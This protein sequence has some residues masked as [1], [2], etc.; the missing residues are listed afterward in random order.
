MD[1][2]K[3]FYLVSKFFIT[4]TIFFRY[5]ILTSSYFFIIYLTLIYNYNNIKYICFIAHGTTR[6]CHLIMNIQREPGE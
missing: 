4:N 1:C 6:A 2:Y 5:K 3:S